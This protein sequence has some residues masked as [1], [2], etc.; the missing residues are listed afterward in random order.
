MDSFDEKFT[1]IDKSPKK[2]GYMDSWYIKEY[3]TAR[4][5]KNFISNSIDKAVEAKMVEV[6]EKIMKHRN[7]EELLKELKED[8]KT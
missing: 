8:A 7:I 3:T 5:L 4:E 6:K 1:P 2:L